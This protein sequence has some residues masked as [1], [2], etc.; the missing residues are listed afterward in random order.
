[1]SEHHGSKG[2]HGPKCWALTLLA[3][4]AVG[5]VLA[6]VLSAPE[7]FGNNSPDV[8]PLLSIPFALLLLSIAVM[9]FINIHFWEHHYPDFAFFLGGIMITF[10]LIYFNGYSYFDALDKE[11][12]FGGYK[13]FHVGMEY[14]QFIALVGS[15]YIVTGGIHIDIKG[16]GSPK[17]N[18]AI[19]AIGAVIANIIGTTG[20]AALLIR[21]YIKINKQ[22]VQAYHVVLFIFIVANCGG[23]LTPIGDPPLFLGYL[24]GV[25]FTWTLIHCV[26]GWLLANVLLL[27]V[28]YVMDTRGLKAWRKEQEEAGEATAEQ[29]KNEIKISGWANFG[30]LAVVLFGVFFDQIANAALHHFHVEFHVHGAGAVLQLAAAVA[31]YK[32]SDP[33]NLKANE[34]TFG[35][36]KEVALIFVGLFATMVPAL[37]YLDIH[38]KDLGLNSPTTFYWLTGSLSSV[39]DNA[40]TYVTFLQAAHGISGMTMGPAGVGETAKWVGELNVAGTGIAA[41]QFLLA[42]SLGAVF[43]G[44]N[45]YIGNAP[46]FMVRA[47]AETSG[48]K[49]P[50]FFGYIIRFSLPILLPVLIVIWVIFF[51]FNLGI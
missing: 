25:P 37:D 23:C 2:F 46:N 29:G 17:L 1:M 3:G 21:A 43:F 19:L 45:T 49:M 16:A 10:Y 31:A 12:D 44:A 39:L 18:V 8:N 26:E 20:A 28:F 50:S 5:A 7:T 36:I 42:I 35:P 27:I 14:F 41:Q 33:K 4:L 11:H 15:L 6:F 47:I 24:K 9:P 51:V 32:L 34:F 38:A 48:V 40:P 30:W 13:M 22:R